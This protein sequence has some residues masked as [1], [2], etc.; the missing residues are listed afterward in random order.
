MATMDRTM[1]RTISDILIRSRQTLLEILED[2]GYDT[3]TYRNIS[4]DQILTLAT[5]HPRALDV[6]VP[7]REG[8]P[9]PC[10]R[11]VVTYMIQDRIKGRLGTIVRDIY[12]ES[13]NE[14]VVATISRKDDVIIIMNEPAH[15]AFDKASL[16]LW[17]TQ[18]ARMT[19]FH[20]KQVV[21]HLGRHVLV[22]PH[23]KLSDEEAK[24]EIERLH[25]TQRAQ[26]PLI[27]YHDI[28]S[29]LMGLVPGD[30]VEII[31]PSPT[32]GVMRYIRL[33][34]A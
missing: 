17:Q 6:I 23:R 34:A 8:S 4:P 30:L 33:C 11:A 13:S 26:L 7:K 25:I 22:P 12:E 5:G 18:K 9:A 32:A 28:Q 2:R 10:D 29:R 24:A 20:I 19:F 3:T 27:K 15:D 21:V 31:R 1:D 14:A 16:Q